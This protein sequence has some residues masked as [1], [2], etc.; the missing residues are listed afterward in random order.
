M[1]TLCPRS[2]GAPRLFLNC[3][4]YPV[5][6][7]SRLRSTCTTSVL[8]RRRQ[9]YIYGLW[10]FVCEPDVR[11]EVIANEATSKVSIGTRSWT[12]TDR[13]RT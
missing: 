12:G 13:D 8:L 11:G 10:H 5:D 2:L 7:R 4:G 9:L 6:N 3:V 1:F